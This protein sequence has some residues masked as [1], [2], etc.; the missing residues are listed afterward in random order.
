[1]GLALVTN[2]LEAE[3]GAIHSELDRLKE[4][5]AELRTQAETLE[6]KCEELEAER[7]EVQQVRDE[8]LAEEAG[9]NMP[10]ED[11]ASLDREVLSHPVRGISICASSP[12]TSRARRHQLRRQILDVTPPARVYEFRDRLPRMHRDGWQGRKT[13]ANPIAFAWYVWDRNYTS[14]TIISRI[15]ARDGRMPSSTPVTP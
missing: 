3:L 6:A 13:K 9:I 1:L 14:P 2:D 4:Q 5:L 15:S 11:D 12:G 10:N 8:H 7:A